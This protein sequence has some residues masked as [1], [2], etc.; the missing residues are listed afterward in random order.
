MRGSGNVSKLR[1]IF[2]PFP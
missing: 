2:F 1:W